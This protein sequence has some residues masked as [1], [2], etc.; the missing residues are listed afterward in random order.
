MLYNVARLLLMASLDYWWI[1]TR[2]FGKP[3][4][5]AI[6]TDNVRVHVHIHKKL[7]FAPNISTVHERIF[8][9]LGIDNL[10]FLKTNE[11]VLNQKN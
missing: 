2:K 3:T 9:I 7:T 6:N 8:L 4:F 5:C 11:V 10:T 1:A